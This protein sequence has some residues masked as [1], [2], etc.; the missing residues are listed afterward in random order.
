[1]NIIYFII[2]CAVLVY[3]GGI[4]NGE[5]NIAREEDEISSVVKPRKPSHVQ[6]EWLERGLVEPGGKLPLFDSNG[7][8]I[9]SRTVESCI[10]HGWAEPWFNN[11]LKPDWQVCK[12]TKMGKRILDN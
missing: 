12:I 10:N 3:G 2:F 5:L 1:M 6:R 7:Q 9:N 4:L 8:R 11:P